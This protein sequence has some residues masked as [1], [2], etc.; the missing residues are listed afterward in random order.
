MGQNFPSSG[1]FEIRR[2]YIG[3]KKTTGHREIGKKNS[4]TKL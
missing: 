1:N 2:W 4:E 3:K